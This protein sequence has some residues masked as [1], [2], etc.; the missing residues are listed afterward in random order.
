[1][2]NVLKNVFRKDKFEE[3]L[4]ANWTEFLDSSKLLAFVLKTVQ[5]NKNR[6]A[7]ISNAKI[8]PKGVSITLSRCHWTPQGFILWVE[9][10]IPLNANQLAEGTIELYLSCDGNIT[11]I[12]MM[13]NLYLQN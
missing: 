2:E 10:N 1:M 11:D 7:V 3:L 9:F 5:A 8:N 6:L 4:I 13:G 12:N